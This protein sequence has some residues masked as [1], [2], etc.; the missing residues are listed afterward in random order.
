MELNYSSTILTKVPKTATADNV[1]LYLEHNR[2]TVGTKNIKGIILRINDDVADDRISV[3]K[4]KLI[5][6][7]WVRKGFL[8]LKKA[9]QE[10]YFY[11]ISLEALIPKAQQ[12]YVPVEID[13]FDPSQSK[14]VIHGVNDAAYDR[15]IELTFI[16][17]S[18]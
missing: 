8:T 6:K 14:I 7:E 13:E 18:L 9:G 4:N 11:E 17:S 1:D 15:D 3:R 5:P 2:G 10:T 12:N 16:H